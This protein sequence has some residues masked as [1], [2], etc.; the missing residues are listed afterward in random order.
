MVRELTQLKYQDPFRG[1]VPF[2]PLAKTTE[3]RGKK[4]GKNEKKSQAQPQSS[5]HSK[6]VPP[7][8]GKSNPSTRVGEQKATELASPLH[9]HSIFP[10]VWEAPDE[11][12]A[13]CFLSGAHWCVI[14]EI[15]DDSTATQSIFRNRVFIRDHRAVPPRPDGWWA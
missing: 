14:G 5:S 2:E 6:I 15:E 4:Q 1:T 8:N 3:P 12:D 13:E 9:D 11:S 7:S 10:L